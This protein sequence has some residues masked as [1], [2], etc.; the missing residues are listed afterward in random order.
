MPTGPCVERYV[1]RLQYS[2]YPVHVLYYARPR[3]YAQSGSTRLYFLFFFPRSRPFF[4]M[5]VCSLPTLHCARVRPH[6]SVLGHFFVLSWSFSVGGMLPGSR[7]VLGVI[8]PP[9]KNSGTL[10]TQSEHKCNRQSHRM[11]NV[12]CC[13]NTRVDKVI[14]THSHI[15]THFSWPLAF[16]SG[17]RL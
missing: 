1:D 2:E 13:C 4:P 11:Q 9:Q 17:C 7:W 15:R 10:S 14:R 3:Y 5:S 8:V 6:W 16:V 12:F